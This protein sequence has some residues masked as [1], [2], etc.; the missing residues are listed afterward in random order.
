MSTWYFGQE[1]NEAHWSE[2]T[3]TLKHTIDIQQ[4]KWHFLHSVVWGALYTV[5]ARVT[6]Y[7]DINHMCQRIVLSQTI[8]T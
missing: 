5:G 2:G 7:A 8:V 6:M 1:N 4:I 3:P